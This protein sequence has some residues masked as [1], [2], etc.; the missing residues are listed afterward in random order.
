MLTRLGGNGFKLKEGS[1]RSE[2]GQKCFAQR[3]VRLCTAA[4]RWSCP[5]LRC[6]R[7]QAGPELVGYA[8]HGTGVGLGGHEDPFQPSRSVTL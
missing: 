5:S 1:C 3:A 6:H 7:L 4:Q 2:G 8:A